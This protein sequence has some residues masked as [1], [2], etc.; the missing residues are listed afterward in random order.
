MSDPLLGMIV[1]FGGNFAPRGWA[2]CDGQLLPISQY[3]ALFSILGT[4]YGGDGRTT[5][6]LPDLR[7][8]AAIH[9]GHG[10]GLSQVTLGE[11]SGAERV[12]LSV[13]NL[14]AHT[15]QLPV[16]PPG[17]SSTTGPFASATGRADPP[18]MRDTTSVGGNIPVETR[19][20]YQA[21]T[22]IIALVGIFPSRS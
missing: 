13:S 1:Q 21:V 9:W 22:F 15:H 17:T 3:S 12:T 14:P 20:P 6:A 8:R 16:V 7:G 2:L 19:S 10:P 11:S 18:A 4:T 5:F